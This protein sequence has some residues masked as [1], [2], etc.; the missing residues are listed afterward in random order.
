MF[1]VNFDFLPEFKEEVR[2]EY[3]EQKESLKGLNLINM[4]AEITEME[5][6]LDSMS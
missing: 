4:Q 3:V 2:L 6:A 1:I 5:K